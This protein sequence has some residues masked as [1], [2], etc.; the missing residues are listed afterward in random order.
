MAL[1]YNVSLKALKSYAFAKSLG[2]VSQDFN[3]SQR[4]KFIASNI[5]RLSKELLVPPED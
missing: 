1:L 4:H 2:L 5:L 3:S